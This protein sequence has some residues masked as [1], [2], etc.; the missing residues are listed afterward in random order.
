M[1]EEINKDSKLESAISAFIELGQIRNQ[2][3]HQ[4]FADFYLEKT[5]E[6]IY[7]LYKDALVF[8]ELFPLKLR[9]YLEQ[10]V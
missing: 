6:E 3:V 9:D 8:V 2:L 7:K 4:N 10:T 1:L 5:S